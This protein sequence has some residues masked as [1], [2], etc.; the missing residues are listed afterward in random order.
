ML[1]K[2]SKYIRNPFF[3]PQTVNYTKSTSKLPSHV[4]STFFYADK[5]SINLLFIAVEPDCNQDAEQMLKQGI[6][7]YFGRSVSIK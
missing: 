5:K 2:S 1:I 7:I 4:I 6:T 3:L